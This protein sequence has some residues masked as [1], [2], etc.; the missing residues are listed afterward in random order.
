MSGTTG[1]GLEPVRPLGQKRSTSRVSA[2][3]AVASYQSLGLIGQGTRQ[4]VHQKAGTRRTC[5]EQLW[6]CRRWQLLQSCLHD[7]AADAPLQHS[8][9]NEHQHPKNKTPGS[10]ACCKVYLV[11]KI[12]GCVEAA[13]VCRLV[14]RGLQQLQDCQLGECPATLGQVSQE[15]LASSEQVQRSGQACGCK[16]QAF[17]NTFIV[18]ELLILRSSLTC[19]VSLYG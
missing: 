7:L 4:P 9:Q 13:E 14:E 17:R 2:A 18:A 15:W 1:G 10:Q 6:N 5:F 12:E 11:D 3:G 19:S 16:R 8:G